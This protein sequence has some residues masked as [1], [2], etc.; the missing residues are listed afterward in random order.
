[1]PIHMR[2][3]DC[4]EKLSFPERRR[5][6][7]ARCGDCNCSILIEE[8]VEDRPRRRSGVKEERSSGGVTQKYWGSG[9]GPE[10]EDA[11]RSRG[12]SRKIR[13]GKPS[14]VADHLG[15]VIIGASVLLLVIG[16]IGTLI[17]MDQDRNPPPRQAGPAITGPP[18]GGVPPVPIPG[19]GPIPGPG[20][21]PG[22]E[23]GPGPVPFPV[24]SRP[25]IEG[26]DTKLLLAYLG[27]PNK[28]PWRT[29]TWGPP[30]VI[31]E[32]GRRKDPVAIPLLVPYLKDFFHAGHARTA[33][34]AFGKDA[35][36]D[37]LAR[38]HDPDQRMREIVRPLLAELN[39][40]PDAILTQT[41]TD[42]PSPEQARRTSALVFL[43]DTK[44]DPARAAEVARAQA[45]ALTD[46][47]VH[48]RDHA[49][50]GLK[51]WG[52]K[53]NT[54]AVAR[55]VEAMAKEQFSS[56]ALNLALEVLK[57][58]RDPRAASSLAPLLTNF[59]L[60]RQAEDVLRSLG[61]EAVQY[62]LPYLHSPEPFT[63]QAARKLLKEWKASDDL[64]LAQ[65]LQDVKA[66]DG[67]RRRSAA[68]FLAQM[69]P[70]E[71]K[72][73]EVAQA[74][75]S[76]LQDPDPFARGEAWRAMK[77]W[78]HK[79]MVPGLIAI[80]SDP[81]PQTPFVNRNGAMDILAEIRD[82]RAAEALAARLEHILEQ[83]QAARALEAI[84]SAAEP[85]VLKYLAHRDTHTRSAVIQL[86]GKIGTLKSVPELEKVGKND[87]P[88]LVGYAKQAVETIRK[89]AATAPEVEP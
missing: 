89:R 61:P 82:P 66:K 10:D 47:D 16:G 42:L 14:W 13:P 41:L 36:K 9:R 22:P 55:L 3:P 18:M 6:E 50:R 31:E 49:L 38:Y 54:P 87:Y 76:L 68:G 21:G 39:T 2:C 52:S 77:P 67:A 51:E 19:G 74:L 32:L 7:K 65:T 43:A 62:V 35:E 28:P 33:L 46:T 75:S 25:K 57:K 63:F 60:C 30:Q 12:G 44:P 45:K 56:G 69:K 20:P 85:A 48:T 80:L 73:A 86:L 29:W 5:G 15:W 53:E 23:P 24:P 81:K 83:G 88:V 84:G 4:G 72:R 11:P 27:N 40:S 1:M 64:L 59:F 34:K 71:E 58:W 79:E 70:V 37:L 78:A 26:V 17:W 8:D